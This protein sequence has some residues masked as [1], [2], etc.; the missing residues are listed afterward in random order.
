MFE[1]EV[2]ESLL[3]HRNSIDV[4]RIVAE[5]FEPYVEVVVHNLKAD[6][7]PILEIYN[8]HV[9]GRSVGD[10]T[11]LFLSMNHC[12]ERVVSYN[13]V[14]NDV[15]LKSSSIVLKDSSGSPEL[16]ISFNFD[17][18]PMEFFQQYLNTFIQT[19][20][21]ADTHSSQ[22]CAIDLRNELHKHLM[23]L[24]LSLK[25]LTKMEY[26]RLFKSLHEAG[27]LNAHGMMTILSKELKI[28][29]KTLYKYRYEALSEN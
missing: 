26:V 13:I 15:V 6:H 25:S 3:R 8:A 9:S 19:S 10:F 23:R 22:E 4:A 5:M 17:V 24:N 21:S 20:Q 18:K 1:K 28:T 29:R 7:Y 11:P 12:N 27:I 2:E 16:G 14:V